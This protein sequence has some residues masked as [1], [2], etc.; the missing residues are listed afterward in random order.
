M[1]RGDAE[2]EIRRIGLDYA[3]ALDDCRP[4]L[5]D[6][7]FAEDAVW[8]NGDDRRRGIRQIRL[9][10]E[11]LAAR[12]LRTVHR[13]HNQRVE[14]DDDGASATTYCTA[15]HLQ[16]RED[17][18]LEVYTVTIRYDDRLRF[19]GSWRIIERV[20]RV[21]WTE[22]RPVAAWVGPVMPPDRVPLE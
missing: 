21:E 16:R 5:L 13:I 8:R 12:W 4:G 9:I 6:R 14:F 3:A 7:I 20:L 11:R 17:G 18:D 22:R 15:D 19:D 1:E 10:P 2:V